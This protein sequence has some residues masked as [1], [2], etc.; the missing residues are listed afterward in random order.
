MNTKKAKIYYSRIPMGLNKAQKLQFLEEK[1]HIFNVGLERIIPDAKNN[2]LTA[3]LENDFDTFAPIGSKEGKVSKQTEGVIFKLYGR[4]IATSRDVWA[5]NFNRDEL[6]KNMR[7][8]IENYNEHVFRYSRLVEKPEIDSFVTYDDQKLSWSRDLKLDLK[9]G[10][11][12]EFLP[13]KMRTSLYRPFTKRVLF[14]DRIMNEEVYQFPSIFPT[15]ETEQENR[16]IGM[17][18]LG[19]EKP[20]SVLMFKIIPDLNMISP[21]AG[22]TQ[23]FPF[24]IYDEAGNHRQEN[25][26]DWAL[27]DYQAHY[28]DEN[29][30]KWDIFYYVYGVLHH[31]GYRDKYAANLKRELPR[32]PKLK[33]FWKLSHA[34]KQLAELHLNY[35]TQK[36]FPLKIETHD[37]LDW[38]VEKMRFNK[39][40]T[41]IKYN[42]SLTLSGIPPEALEYKLGNRSALDWIIDQYQI[43]TDKRSGISNDP[44]NLDEP[45][46][47]VKLIRR[48]VTVSVET[49]GMVKEISACEL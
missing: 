10:K 19:L 21:G 49:V 11:F 7:L 17:N 16:V 1:K 40:K 47:I 44:N 9:R 30:G 6:A 32:I 5:Y 35:E 4:G 15:S 42:D 2:W 12:A 3:G 31:Q 20:F 23:C 37:V 34:G 39:E 45:Q 13:E 14:F 26:T 22:G 29:I 27:K 43:S 38:R 24:Y 25:I 48:I 41:A 8:T 28:A 36:E 18:G 46:Y 33:D